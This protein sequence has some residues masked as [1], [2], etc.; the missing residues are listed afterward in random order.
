[1]LGE[2]YRAIRSGKRLTPE[3]DGLR[4]EVTGGGGTNEIVV[5][6]TDWDKFGAAGGDDR[7]F[8]LWRVDRK[9]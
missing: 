3:G 6:C 7:T 5:E 9:A 8:I 1:L 2:L 4:L